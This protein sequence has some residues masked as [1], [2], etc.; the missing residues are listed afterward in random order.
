[1]LDL[2]RANPVGSVNYP[3]TWLGERVTRVMEHPLSQDPALSLTVHRP[4]PF[5]THGE[6][7]ARAQ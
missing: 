1:M 2:Q 6:E 4:A 7:S 5:S 3:V